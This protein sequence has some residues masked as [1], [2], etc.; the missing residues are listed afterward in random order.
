MQVAM[1][2]FKQWCDLLSIQGA[3]N[4]TY[5]SISKLLSFQKITFMK[6]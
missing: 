5:I 2:D 4:G 3:I 1:K 6:K